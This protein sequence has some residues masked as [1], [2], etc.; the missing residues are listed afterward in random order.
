MENFNSMVKQTKYTAS[1]A[2]IVFRNL[3][4]QVSGKGKAEPNWSG[5]EKEAR[6]QKKVCNR[7][8]IHT[9]DIVIHFLKVH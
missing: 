9:P 2:G 6:S 7:L 4:G 5:A 8:D 3:T 1:K